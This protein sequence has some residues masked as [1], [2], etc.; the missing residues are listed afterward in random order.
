MNLD[1]VL[2]LNHPQLTIIAALLNTDD[3]PFR[4]SRRVY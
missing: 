3:M 4:F 1:A 2:Q